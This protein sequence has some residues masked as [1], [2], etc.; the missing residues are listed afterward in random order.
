MTL[1]HFRIFITVCDTMNMTAAAE[2][3][4]ISQSAVSQSIAEL[5]R[6]YHV[7]LFERLSRKLYL[8]P[9]GKKLLG[10][11]RHMIHINDDIEKDMKALYDQGF[12]RIGA[13]VTVGTD[14][15]PSMVSAFKRLNPETTVEVFEDNTEQIEK[16]LLNDQTDIGLIEGEIVSPDIIEIPFMMMNL[17]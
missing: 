3:L 15:L 11:A 14:V 2:L 13:S 7:R 17:S 5:E 9:A 8:T 12:L 1:R 6:Y 4:F 16:R 10:Y